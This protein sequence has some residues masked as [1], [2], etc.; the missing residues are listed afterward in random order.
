MPEDAPQSKDEGWGIV[1]AAF[2]GVAGL[3]ALLYAWYKGLIGF[4]TAKAETPQEACAR[5]GGI[6]NEMAQTC[7]I[8]KP[9]TDVVG[10]STGSSVGGS[11]SGSVVVQNDKGKGSVVDVDE[12]GEGSTGPAK[13]KKCADGTVIPVGQDC[14]SEKIC[15][16]ITIS[17]T[18]YK[19]GDVIKFRITACGSSVPGGWLTLKGVSLETGQ[20]ESISHPIGSD[21]I[22]TADMDFKG[23][24]EAT[25]QS[26]ALGGRLP[27]TAVI[28]WTGMPEVSCTGRPLVVRNDSGEVSSWNPADP[29]NDVMLYCGDNPLPGGSW[30]AIVDADGKEYNKMLGSAEGAANVGHPNWPN[31]LVLGRDWQGDI[32]IRVTSGIGS[33]LSKKLTK[34]G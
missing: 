25:V 8:L 30:V 9:P 11:A 4:P 7:E 31:I 5:R 12:K 15:D 28:K 17:P 22:A 20:T 6:W 3:G 10:T 16:A 26:Q 33:G 21:G 18:S 14:P 19:T 29:Y 34:G 24:V 13:T 27:A 23:D 2:A 1:I 32:T